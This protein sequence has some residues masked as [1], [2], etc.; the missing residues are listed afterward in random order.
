MSRDDTAF[1]VEYT[2]GV[3]RTCYEGWASYLADL[4]PLPGYPRY[5]AGDL[6]GCVGMW[7]SGSWYDQRAINYIKGVKAHLANKEWL[8]PGF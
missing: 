6:W 2:Y 4:T 8:Q 1:N 3:I 5:H 7:Y